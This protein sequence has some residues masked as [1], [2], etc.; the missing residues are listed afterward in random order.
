MSMSSINPSTNDLI[1]RKIS[2]FIYK[3]II[4]LR[5]ELRAQEQKEREE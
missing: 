5:K 4:P 2:G 3:N 1:Q